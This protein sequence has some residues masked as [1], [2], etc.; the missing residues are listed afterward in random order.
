MNRLTRFIFCSLFALLL[1]AC[2]KPLPPDKISY[3]GVWQSPTMGLLITEDGTV[4]YKR[5][6]GG[7]TVSVNGPIQ[8]FE[9]NNFTVGVGPIHT[10]FIVTKIPYQDGSEIKMVVDGVSLVRT[11]NAE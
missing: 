11:G 2:G 7:G 9:G 3:S 4:S 8:S 10:L 1:S 6:K 5:L